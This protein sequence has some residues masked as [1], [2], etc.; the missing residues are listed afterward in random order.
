MVSIHAQ[1]ASRR[2]KALAG[3]HKR[4]ATSYA[5]RYVSGEDLLSLAAAVDAPPCSLFR[6]VVEALCGCG[7]AA[8]GVA[9]RDPSLL[10]PLTPN[11]APHPEQLRA[12]LSDDAQR[13]VA[14]D[15]LCSP[16]V[17]AAKAAAGAGGEARL[18]EHLS[19]L[20]VPFTTEA[21]LRSGGF[22]RTPD[23]RLDVP[24]L[25]NGRLVC[26]VDSKACFQDPAVHAAQGLPQFTAYVNRYGPGCV[27]YW[28]GRVEG[29]EAHSD[30]LVLSAFPRSCD[31]TTLDTLEMP[32]WVP[33]AGRAQ[34]EK[35][36]GAAA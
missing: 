2:V 9:L 13:C 27:I 24:I 15:H 1:E 20:G 23:A 22:A 21:A 6:L 19:S 33:P 4:A 11:A 36:G 7:P 35:E 8:S 28:S 18:A 30:V 17:E 34:G 3:A 16:L 32:G 14:W 5:S 29:L 10:P 26:W 12:R 31:V 25:V